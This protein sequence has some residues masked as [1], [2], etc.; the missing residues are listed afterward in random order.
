MLIADISTKAEY[1]QCEHIHTKVATETQIPGL[2]T[3]LTLSYSKSQ[4]YLKVKQTSLSDNRIQIDLD[5]Q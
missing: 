1:Y 4:T 3:K 2:L 5:V